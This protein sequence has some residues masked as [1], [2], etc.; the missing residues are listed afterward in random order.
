MTLASALHFKAGQNKTR[1]AQA[2]RVFSF[3]NRKETASVTIGGRTQNGM[4]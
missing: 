4:L 2:V 3:G 1:T